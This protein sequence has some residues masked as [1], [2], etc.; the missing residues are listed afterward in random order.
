MHCSLM[1]V[2]RIFTFCRPSGLTA[3]ALAALLA[4]CAS[5]GDAPSPVAD[6]STPAQTT[7]PV[8]SLGASMPAPATSGASVTNAT[9]L[10]NATGPASGSQNAAAGAPSAPVKPTTRTLTVVP[11]PGSPAQIVVAKPVEPP[12]PT[13]LWDRIRNGFGMPELDTPLVAEK[14]R[15]YTQKPE[16]LQRMFARGGRYLYYIVDEVEKRGMPTE[17]ALLPF[18]ESAMNPSALSSAKAAG[19]WQF[20]PSTGKQYNLS[21][22]WW[23]DSRRDPVHSTQAAL[24]YLQSIYTMHGDDWFLAL[25]SYNWG[26]NAVARAV[27]RNKSKG[28]PF[29]YL[30]LDMPAETR[31]YVPKLIALKNIIAHAAEMGIEL[32]PLPNK[33]Y[34]VTI[35]K[36]G[37]IDLK[38]AAQFAGMSVEEFVALNPA[39]NRPVIA[40]S[41]A[42]EIKLPADRL[43][44]FMEAVERHGMANKPFA[45][46]QPHTLAAGETLDSVAGRAGI[47]VA[48]LRR[49][50]S[51]DADMRPIAGTR[52]IAPLRK[53]GATTTE[54]EARI[55]RFEG[56][57]VY[58][59]VR[60]PAVY[61]VVGKSET[62]YSIASRYGT[63]AST[64]Q[65]MNGLK[66]AA[67]HRG[68]SLMVRPGSS[69][70]MLTDERGAK[71]VVA[72]AI[73]E[74]ARPIK[75]SAPVD[76]P[77][78]ASR[79]SRAAAVSRSVKGR[80]ASE[81]VPARAL[82]GKLHGGR[83]ATKAAAA[84]AADESTKPVAS[85]GAAKAPSSKQVVSPARQPAAA[86]QIAPAAPKAAPAP[87]PHKAT[88]ERRRPRT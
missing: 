72:T 6:K 16:Y 23:A 40:A 8:A 33:P 80:A 85:K 69:Q 30:S 15:F 51:L 38:L 68:M 21:Q 4:G 70:T 34:F 28:R 62:L 57:R 29:D 54:D 53:A 24:D 44:A 84:K 36:T 75:V 12:G 65:G 25:A 43:D 61:H 64:L 79:P 74:T 47:T 52:I 45:S 37:P 26:E 83:S 1:I 22:D 63:S 10:A 48:E 81:P 88:T 14:E 86:R 59:E 87:A 76:E 3:I 66:S 19:L 39:H 49:A 11:D 67:V 46:W 42:N 2:R 56:P 41:K 27:A 20:I 35:E 7:R 55:E 73:D 82:V 13:N 5:T 17:L 18:V 32:P 60:R 31:S 71:Q 58:E 50:N 9:N 78:P 77:E